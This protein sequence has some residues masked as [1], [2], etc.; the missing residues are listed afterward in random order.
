MTTT[1]D[2]SKKVAGFT[3]IEMMI[4]L[5]VGLFILGAVSAVA[6]NSAKSSRANDR[7]SEM[8]TNG[9]YALDMLR[10]DVQHAGQSGL[11]P[12]ADLL[13]KKSQGFFSVA[14]GVAVTS[15]CA[16]GFSLKL[17]EPIWGVNDA[18][19]GVTACIPNANYVRGDILAVRYAD[20]T[21]WDVALATVTTP[22]AAAAT[23]DIYY[24]SSYDA[25]RIYKKG[26]TAPTTVGSGP[27]QDQLLKSYVY[28]VSPNT[29]AGDGIPALFRMSLVAGTMTSELVA[30]GIENLQVR[31]GVVDANTGATQYLDAQNLAVTDWPL[32][33]SVRVWI[34]A[35]NST[36]ER[37]EQYSNVASQV[38]GDVTYVPTVGTNDQFR[39]QLYTTTINLR[40]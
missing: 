13:A 11:T 30:T 34:L 5:T 3:L 7:T 12:P 4:A 26:G 27:M 36:S 40:N 15:D 22:P 18:N 2:Q 39:R 21:A 14:S 37:S 10:R 8:Q 31:Y 16:A 29:T 23:G 17:E 9:R 33:Q 19:T 38:M 25:A 32:V 28:Y 1:H 35:R 24:R 6:L 20:T